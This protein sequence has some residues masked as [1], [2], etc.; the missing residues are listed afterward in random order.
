MKRRLVAAILLLAP[1]AAHAFPSWTTAARWSAERQPK[2]GPARSIGGYAAGCLQGGVALPES[3]PGFEVMHLHRHRY[4][5]HPTL[6][7]FVGRLAAGAQ[8]SELPALLVGDLSQPRGGPTPSDHASHQSG[9]DVDI[10]YTRPVQLLSAPI[11]PN[12]RESI[13]PPAVVDLASGKLSAAWT[14]MAAT[15]VE[16]AASD[17][18]VD[19]IFVNAWIKHSLCA[20]SPGAPWLGKLRP[21]WGHHDHF[22]VRLTCPSGSPDCRAQPPV[23]AGD[24]CDA[25]LAWWLGDGP[26]I[27]RAERK[28]EAPPSECRQVLR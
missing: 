2:A 1:L 13:Q 19:R 8:R 20:A 4:F 27:T 17:P 28:R 5:G 16:L 6:V 26:R 18:A 23:P 11:P 12:E 7:G 24:G 22:H 10:G 9:L 15:L 25:S 3:G 21:W 14:P